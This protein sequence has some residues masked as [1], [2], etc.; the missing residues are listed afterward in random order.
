ML[1]K[2]GVRRRSLKL[3]KPFPFETLPKVQT[4]NKNLLMKFLDLIRLLTT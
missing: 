1:Q 2:T 3:L 4:L